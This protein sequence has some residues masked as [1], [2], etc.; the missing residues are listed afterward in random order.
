MENHTLKKTNKQTF[1]HSSLVC[2][3]LAKTYKE[4]RNSAGLI[5][6]QKLTCHKPRGHIN[7]Y[8]EKKILKHTYQ[9]NLHMA[10]VTVFL[11]VYVWV[12]KKILKN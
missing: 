3:L 10:L 9:H 11:N 5:S 1:V 4:G 12:F 8:T 6:V 2:L 7:K